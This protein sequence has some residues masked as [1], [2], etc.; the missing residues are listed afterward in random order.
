MMRKG[1]VDANLVYWQDGQCLDTPNRK[2]NPYRQDTCFVRAPVH[3]V[4]QG[5]EVTLVLP[6]ILLFNNLGWTVDSFKIDVDDGLGWR[7]V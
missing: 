1:G 2:E 5:L 3:Q 4:V 6:D 7:W